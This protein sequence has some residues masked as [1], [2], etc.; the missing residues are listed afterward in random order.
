VRL[1]IS[2]F[3]YRGARRFFNASGGCAAL[4]A[5]RN[6]AFAPRSAVQ[7]RCPLGRAGVSRRAAKA[8]SNRRCLRAPYDPGV[9]APRLFLWPHFFMGMSV[10]ISRHALA[11]ACFGST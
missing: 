2:V 7:L 5:Q 6:F 11:A 1:L 8:R 3:D 4:H 9:V 10:Q